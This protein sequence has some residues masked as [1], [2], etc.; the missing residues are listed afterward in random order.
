MARIVGV[1][2]PKD[3]PIGVALTYIFGLGRSS[4]LKILEKSNVDPG[5]RTRDLKEEQ[6]RDIRTEIQQN[7][8]VEGSLKT[9]INM[10]IKR[11]IDIGSYRG[12]RHKLG[13]PARGQRTRTN[14][15]TRKGRRRPV[16]GKRK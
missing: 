3:K 10:N 14:A 13:L 2:L 15:R 12:N 16:A 9:E 6:V 11:L 8:K 1:D 5:T 4:A 7:Y